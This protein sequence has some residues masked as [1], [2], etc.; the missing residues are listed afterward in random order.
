MKTDSG[1]LDKEIMLAWA[2]H[3]PWAEAMR[4]CMQD[5]EWHA[6]GDVWTHTM[7]VVEELERLAD[8]NMLG[9]RDRLTLLYTALF[10]D[11]GKPATTLNDPETGKVRSPGHSGV[12]AR[13]CR[14]VLRE[15]G[16]E[17]AHRE[18]IVQCVAFHGRP[19]NIARYDDPL[20]EV[21]HTSG[22]VSNL[23]LWRFA[24]ADLRGRRGAK[25]SEEEVEYWKLVCEEAGCLESPY[26]FPSDHARLLFYAGEPTHQGYIPY[27]VPRCSVTL[28][29][30]VAGTGK[31][32]WIRENMPDTPVLALDDIREELKIGPDDNQ[33]IV[34]A[35]ARE[36]CREFLR[37]G[38][39][40]VFNATNLTRDIRKRWID[41][42]LD[43]GARVDV[44][45]LEKPLAVV[46]QQ[47]RSRER[48]VPENII[49]RMFDR[50]EPPTVAEA[51]TV[52]HIYETE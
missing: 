34:I 25:L 30:G 47:N 14:S 27:F 22:M 52:H 21:I 49:R 44:V 19:V 45:Y 51:H 40:F 10:H 37:S 48:Q 2:S 29:S 8:W 5:A 24:T 18:E 4:S 15:L 35:T 6:E 7:M 36:R 31:D 17:L 32:T 46:L 1:V 50:A 20:R 16:V 9:R 3:Q 26:K 38:T 41:L 12:G 28:M 13:L 39:D 11:A 42:C 43:Y 33:G 23:Q